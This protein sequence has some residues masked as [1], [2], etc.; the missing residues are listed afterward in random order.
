MEDLPD[1]LRR[2]VDQLT[3][4]QKNYCQYRAKGLVMSVCAQRA[5]STSKDRGSLSRIGYQIEQMDGTKEYIEFLRGQRSTIA[6]IDENDLMSLLKDVYHRSMKDDNYREANKSA[7]LMAKCLGM[8]TKDV[9]TIGKKDNKATPTADGSPAKENTDPFHEEDE[10]EHDHTACGH[11]R[12]E[13][14]G[15]NFRERRHQGSL[16]R[17]TRLLQTPYEGEIAEVAYR[18]L[19]GRSASRTHYLL[20]IILLVESW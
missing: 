4:L 13:V 12:R 16:I 8:L 20:S 18:I 14:G 17:R 9:I 10:G 5:G 7:E 3:S 1:D 2:K 6:S 11:G 19:S 15:N